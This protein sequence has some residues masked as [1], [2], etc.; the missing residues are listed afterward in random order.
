MEG[1]KPPRDC[2]QSLRPYRKIAILPVGTIHESPAKLAPSVY[3]YTNKSI[4]VI[5]V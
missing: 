4:L 2:K 1:G 5:F 3:P